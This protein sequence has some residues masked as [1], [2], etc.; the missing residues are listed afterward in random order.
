MEGLSPKLIY[1]LHSCVPCGTQIV[2]DTCVDATVLA[3]SSPSP[4]IISSWSWLHLVWML[5]LNLLLFLN[6]LVRRLRGAL[7]NLPFFWSLGFRP[8][9]QSQGSLW[10]LHTWWQLSQLCHTALLGRGY[11]CSDGARR[12]SSV[13]GNI[14]SWQ[15]ALQ[16]GSSSCPRGLAA[17]FPLLQC[18]PRTRALG[19][20]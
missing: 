19:H 6:S 18:R 10:C 11:G 16:F 7:E 3:S 1:M 17:V 2:T 4:A 5:A 15:R 12:A 20:S 14:E 8:A 9:L 13:R